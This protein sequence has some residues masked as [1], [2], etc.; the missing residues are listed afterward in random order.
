MRIIIYC[1]GEKALTSLNGLSSDYR[2]LISMIVI[3]ED[4]NVVDDKSSD[5]ERFAILNNINYSYRTSYIKNSS[6]DYHLAIG[7]RWMINLEDDNTNLIVIHDSL[8]PRYRGF[9]PLVSALINGDTRIGASMIWASDEYDEGDI[10]FQ[11]DIQINYP[12]KIIEAIQKISGIYAVLLSKFF[13]YVH[14]EIDLPRIAQDELNVSYSLWR[15]ENDYLIN[16]NDNAS[17]IVR[18]IDAVGFPYLSASTS[19][20]EEK[21]RI[22][23]AVE[24]QDVCIEN[25]TPGK[26]I[27]LENNCPTIVCGK[28]LVKIIEAKDADNNKK[29][30]NKFRVKLV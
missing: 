16:W 30:F 7:W 6:Y 18:M 20:D 13:K 15:N 2:A 24:V 21:I 17:S 29:I 1:L 27:F 19:Y 25:R 26:I 10:I 28:G 3:G 5:I 11:E 8:L 22:I 12:I 14:Q 23:E 9:N 4:K